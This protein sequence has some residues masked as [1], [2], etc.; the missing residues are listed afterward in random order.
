MKKLL[1]TLFIFAVV[2]SYE[3]PDQ[4]L[5]EVKEA[6]DYECSKIS[7][8]KPTT[9]AQYILYLKKDARKSLYDKVME[10]RKFKTY[11]Q[12]IEETDI[13]Q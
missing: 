7:T 3:I 8:E 6:V 2:I 11:Q 12:S 10:L 5:A 1:S 4:Y 9:N 13:T